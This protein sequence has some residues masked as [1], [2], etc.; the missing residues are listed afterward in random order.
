[1]I[2]DGRGIPQLSFKKQVIVNGLDYTCQLVA[3]V[4]ASV[5]SNENVTDDYEEASSGEAGLGS[6]G[7]TFFESNVKALHRCV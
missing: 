5:R 7:E 2:F 6:R 3:D 4:N 1:L